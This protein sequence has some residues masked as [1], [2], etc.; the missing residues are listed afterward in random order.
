M[1]MRAHASV[2]ACVRVGMCARVSMCM[3]VH[4]CPCRARLRTRSLAFMAVHRTHLLAHVKQG[5]AEEG[6]LH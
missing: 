2:P 1:F 4:V 5:G 6:E 3:C